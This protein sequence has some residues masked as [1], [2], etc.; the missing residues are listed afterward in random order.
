LTPLSIITPSLNQGDF[1]ERTIRSVLNQDITGLEYIVVDGG[2]TDVTLNILR[3]FE[4]R[5]A[6]IS[7]KDG[8]QADAVNKG[9]KATKGEIIGWVNSDDIYYPDALRLVVS[10]F[11][12]H[13]EIDVIYGNGN[14][15][16]ID[17]SM[18]EPYLT[19]P[20]DPERLKSRCFVCQP[21]VFFRRR[22]IDR[23]GVLDQRL[24]YCLDYE[25]WLRLSQEGATFFHIAE[26]LAGTRLH[27]ST[28]TIGERMKAIQET[29]DMLSRKLGYVPDEW[30]LSYA[31]TFL[32]RKGARRMQGGRLDSSIN[33]I[34]SQRGRF[35]RSLGMLA[36]A[37]LLAMATVSISFLASL[38][39]NRS[40]SRNMIRITAEWLRGYGGGVGGRIFSS[41]SGRRV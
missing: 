9:I 10:L 20:W 5:L 13:P 4:D 35:G 15:I 37:P 41:F 40:I 39:W 29:I 26:V 3:R 27:P 8:G 11:E 31:R 21:A 24:R 16:T 12:K 25:F 7:E 33:D 22:V 1:I 28:K 32:N 6:W 17:D 38:R 14:H 36:V 23:C 18:I 30:L 34:L 19:E 2:S